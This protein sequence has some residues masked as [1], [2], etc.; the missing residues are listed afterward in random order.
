MRDRE[1]G[2]KPER[3]RVGGRGGAGCVRGGGGHASSLGVLCVGKGALRAAACVARA[4][5]DVGPL[6][7]WEPGSVDNSHD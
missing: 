2:G 6:S 3:D 7:A 4:L 5:L 1:R